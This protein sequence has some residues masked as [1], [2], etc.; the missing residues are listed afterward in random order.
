M[1]LFHVITTVI[2]L[3]LVSL[4][5]ANASAEEFRGH[6]SGTQ[7][8]TAYDSNDDGMV[9]SVED[10]TGRFSHLGKV[11]VKG[12]H[13]NSGLIE[14]PSCSETEVGIGAFYFHL[15][16][17][18]A[19]GDMLFTE[20]FALDA[21]WNLLDAS[22]QAI[23]HMQI[24]GGTGRFTGATGQFDCDIAAS[25]LFIPE[26]NPFAYTWEGDCYGELEYS[27]LPD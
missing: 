22:W 10:G 9:A 21:C 19:N 18:A 1:K 25:P 3:S 14:N 17:T 5:P 13:E 7:F 23:F 27:G 4:L 12:I 8:P 6:M 16:F 24:T 2:L 26:N 15:I 20:Q 11:T